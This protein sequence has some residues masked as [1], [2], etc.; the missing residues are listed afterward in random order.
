RLIA[1]GKLPPGA[2]LDI[3]Q[4]LAGLAGSGE[5][6]VTDDGLP[7]RQILSLTFPDQQHAQVSGHVSVT[8]SHFQPVAPAA[9]FPAAA[10]ADRLGGLLSTTYT[11]LVFASLAL[12]LILKWRSRA[13]QR[14]MAAVLALAL[15]IGPL[16]TDLKLA[17]FQRAQVAQAAE[18]SQQQQAAEQQR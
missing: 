16:L 3:A 5:L 7:L 14:A 18:Q 15:A 10:L 9:T 8:F 2:S 4:Q 11:T 13:L 1:T 17:D 12:L 6:W